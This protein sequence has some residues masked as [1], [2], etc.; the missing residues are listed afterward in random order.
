MIIRLLL[1]N[2]AFSSDMNG[3]KYLSQVNHARNANGAILCLSI[4]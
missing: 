1:L 4:A 2:L 3:R